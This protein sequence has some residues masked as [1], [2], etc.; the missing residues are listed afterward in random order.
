VGADFAP[1]AVLQD[2]TGL[3]L[4]D[5]IASGNLIMS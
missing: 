3:L 4:N 2:V 5:L 1:L